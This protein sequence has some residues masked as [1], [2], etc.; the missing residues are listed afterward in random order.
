MDIWLIVISIAILVVEY[1]LGSTK[2]IK[3]NSLI[4]TVLEAGKGVL[5]YLKDQR[6]DDVEEKKAE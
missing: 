5:L 4:E 6:E 3:P 2:V 1:F